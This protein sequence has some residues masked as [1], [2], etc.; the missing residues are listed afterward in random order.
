[1][2][3]QEFHDNVDALAGKFTLEERLNRPRLAFLRDAILL[4]EIATQDWRD[5]R[6]LGD[7]A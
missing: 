5:K 4:S 3:P 1:M 7:C 2:H 6:S